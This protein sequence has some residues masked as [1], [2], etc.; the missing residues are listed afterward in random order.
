[1][2]D[3]RKFALMQTEDFILSE[4]GMDHCVPF[5]IFICISLPFNLSNQIKDVGFKPF[6]IQM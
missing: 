2:L 3:H 4:D 6:V 1:M 5:S